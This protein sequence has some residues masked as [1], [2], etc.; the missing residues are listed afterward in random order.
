MGAVTFPGGAKPA[1]AQPV[2][3][4]RQLQ[5]AAAVVQAVRDGE[6]GTASLVRVDTALR[7]GVQALAFHAL[8]NLGRAQAL[9]QQLARR[10]PPPAVDALL[11]TALALAWQDVGAPYEAFTLVD[12][13]VEAAKRN[14][15]TRGQ[16]AFVNA[17]L[18]RFLRERQPLVD[19]TQRDEVAVWN[20]PSWWIAQ[21]AQGPSPAL[22]RDP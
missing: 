12:Q 9:R 21:A 13:A 19:A 2:P 20:H 8:R 15:A 16:A 22:A 18:R 11:C 3:L 7:P 5:A 10:A 1:V 14:P 4:W 17:C 6:S